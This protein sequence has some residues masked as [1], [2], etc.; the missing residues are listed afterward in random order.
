M[1]IRVEGRRG[2]SRC[3]R[4]QKQFGRAVSDRSEA[5]G[6]AG[7]EM[8]GIAWPEQLLFALKDEFQAA[9]KDIDPLFAVVLIETVVASVRRHRYLNGLESVKFTRAGDRAVAQPISLAQIRTASADYRAQRARASF[10]VEQR[11]NG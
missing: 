5:M 2:R 9:R 6:Y 7:I 10:R 11:P 4:Y 3:R 1:L 8:R